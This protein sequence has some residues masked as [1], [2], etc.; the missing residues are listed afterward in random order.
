MWREKYAQ[1]SRPVRLTL[2]GGLFLKAYIYEILYF[3]LRDAM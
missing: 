1:I 3:L 2:G